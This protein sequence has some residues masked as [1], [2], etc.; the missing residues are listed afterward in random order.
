MIFFRNFTPSDFQAKNFYTVKVFDL[1]HFSLKTECIKDQYF[2]Q[3]LVINELR[4]S[5]VQEIKAQK[6]SEL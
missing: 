3:F 6:M 4:I 1:R 5:T 2:G